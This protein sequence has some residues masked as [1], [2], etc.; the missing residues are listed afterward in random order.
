[1]TKKKDEIIYQRLIRKYNCELKRFESL[2][3]K[4]SS[5]M[6]INIL[7]LTIEMTLIVATVMGLF[8]N[9]SY[10]PEMIEKTFI[11]LFMLNVICN[12]FSLYYLYQSHK[13]MFIM[14]DNSE[15]ELLDYYFDEKNNENYENILIET[16]SDLKKNLELNIILT[17][18]K[19]KKIKKGSILLFISEILLIVD[20][21]LFLGSMLVII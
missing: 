5:L 14:C 4:G 8:I 21:I 12:S 13:S 20:L 1:M 16:I 11:L 3:S 19:T 2:D 7:V 6:N 10:F 17:N 18:S 9:I 15:T